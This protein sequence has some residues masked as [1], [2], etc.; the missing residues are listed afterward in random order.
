MRSVPSGRHPNTP[1][2]LH[3]LLRF[4]LLD[5]SRHTPYVSSHST[6]HNKFITTTTQQQQQQQQ[7]GDFTSISSVEKPVNRQQPALLLLT[8]CRI[9]QTTL[10]MMNHSTIGA[11]QGRFDDSVARR[12]VTRTSSTGDKK[13][14]WSSACWSA[15]LLRIETLSQ[16]RLVKYVP[17]RGYLRAVPSQKYRKKTSPPPPPPPIYSLNGS[18]D[19][20]HYYTLQHH[21]RKTTQAAEMMTIT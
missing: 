17:G 2:P 19:D 7:N 9:L 3:V 13:T 6:L 10:R 18:H 20:S 12:C 5:A 1:Q 15:N 21:H 16:G 11:R 14:T 4:H 8:S